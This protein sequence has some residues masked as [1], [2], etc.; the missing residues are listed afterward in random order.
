MHTSYDD[1]ISRI[2]TP[3]IWFD[4]HAVPRY[5]AFEPARS[6]NIHIGEIALVEITCQSCKRKFHVALSAVN[7]REGTIAQAIR[8]KTL[9]YGDPPRHDGDPDDLNACRAGASMNSEPRRVIEYWYR[10]DPRFVKGTRVIN[11]DYFKWARDPSLEVDI[12]RD[13][14]NQR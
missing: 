3:P 11:M 8:S 14:I 10:H 2:S 1:I 12:Q 4:E 7:F 13:R 9:H 6:A 5:C